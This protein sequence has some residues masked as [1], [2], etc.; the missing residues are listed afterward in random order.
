MFHHTSLT[1]P[2]GPPGHL[3]IPLIHR[4]G[5]QREGA[6]GPGL[7]MG[8]LTPSQCSGILSGPWAASCVWCSGAAGEAAQRPWKEEEAADKPLADCEPS[9]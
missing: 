6:T 7:Q 9:V 3:P 4:K 5:T 8:P 1:K 2:D